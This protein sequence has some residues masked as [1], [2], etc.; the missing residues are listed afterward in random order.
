[1]LDIVREMEKFMVTNLTVLKL[2]VNPKGHVFAAFVM[3]L[4]R[5]RH[6]QTIL[7]RL[8]IVLFGWFEVILHATYISYTHATSKYILRIVFL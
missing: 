6:I 1:M 8:E 5:M 2:R 7:R 3:R 4:L